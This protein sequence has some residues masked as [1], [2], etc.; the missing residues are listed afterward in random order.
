M[1]RR[2]LLRIFAVV[3]LATALIFF[4]AALYGQKE[5]GGRT[6]SSDAAVTE[7]SSVAAAENPS[8]TSLGARSS[9]ALRVE[10][11]CGFEVWLA[12]ENLPGAAAITKLLPE[13][14]VDFT[15]PAKGAA[16]TRFWP[17]TGCDDAGA[18]CAIGQSIPPCPAAGCAPPVDSKLE[19]TWPCLLS[20]GCAK[21]PSNGQPLT[22]TLWW[23][24]SA[25]DGFT[26]P[27]VVRVTPDSGASCEPADC[28]HLLLRDCPKN[29]DLSDRGKNPAYS[30]QN[31]AVRAT[32]GGPMAGCFAPYMKLNYPV[33]GGDGLLDPGGPV[34][35]MYAC[36]TPP[37]TPEE[38]RAG[39]VT[40]TKYVR[41]IHAACKKSVYAFAY[42]DAIG[43]RS[44]PGGTALELVFCPKEER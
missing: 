5:Q 31:E 43:L 12:A 25:V 10:N 14:H 3:L 1:A 29:D 44:C 2:A 37:V 35:K 8:A 26:L 39:P 22:S 23:N 18:N 27:F 9:S 33:W 41:L 19:A 34:E 40:A 32:D 13:D 16:A 38:C 4:F 7:A 6:S 17:K 21:N 30:S 36:P 24:A 28:A 20:D 15:I 11:A 42:D